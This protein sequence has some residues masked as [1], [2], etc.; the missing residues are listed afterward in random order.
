MSVF[1]SFPWVGRGVPVLVPVRASPV[2]SV[3]RGSFVGF[4]LSFTRRHGTGAHRHEHS[5]FFILYQKGGLHDALYAG[6]P[7]PYW[8]PPAPFPLEPPHNAQWR[9]VPRPRAPS[10]AAARSPLP[11]HLRRTNKLPPEDR[12]DP[13]SAVDKGLR[14]MEE[15]VQATRYHLERRVRPPAVIRCSAALHRLRPGPPKDITV[16]PS[17]AHRCLLV[18]DGR[19]RQLDLDPPD[20]HETRRPSSRNLARTSRPSSSC[21]IPSGWNPSASRRSKERIS[22]EST[23]CHRSGHVLS[24]TSASTVAPP[25]KWVRCVVERPFSRSMP[26]TSPAPATLKSTAVGSAEVVMTTTTLVHAK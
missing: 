12:A 13:A 9:A 2:P 4:F 6:A 20:R 21:T 7:A 16:C 25:L 18:V 17:Q 14:P 10:R 26:A 19:R 5:V 22:A 24:P 8:V 1:F 11:P 15:H 3:V 23:A